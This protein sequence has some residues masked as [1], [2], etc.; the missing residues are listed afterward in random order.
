VAGVNEQ[1]EV[2]YFVVDLRLDSYRR[3]EP[4]QFSLVINQSCKCRLDAIRL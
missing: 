4:D 2:N 3:N 1:V